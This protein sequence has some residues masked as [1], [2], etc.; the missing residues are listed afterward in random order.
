MINELE[1]YNETIFDN[2]KHIDKNGTEYWFARE[3]MVALKYKEW[4]YFKSIIDKAILSCNNSNNNAID[5]FGVYTQMIKVAKG[6]KR[7]VDDYKL[8]R[9][10]CYL[11][12]QN[13]NPNNKAVALGQTYFAIQTRKQEIL[14]EFEK[15]I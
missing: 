11:I 14:E 13:A 15:F 2:I 9:Y 5:H 7:K 10:A 12:V 3:L 4:R 1:K 6:A 8:S